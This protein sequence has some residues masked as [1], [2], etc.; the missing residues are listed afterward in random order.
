MYANKVKVEKTVIEASKDDSPNVDG[1]TDGNWTIKSL[2]AP[3]EIA[4]NDS[5]VVIFEDFL[6]NNFPIR[7]LESI[8]VERKK[9]R[10]FLDEKF[11][12]KQGLSFFDES[13]GEV[14]KPKILY[15]SN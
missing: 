15:K 8:E 12:S 5:E 4:H 13:T 1:K 10:D 3:T 2:N 11:N 6:E 14:L 7:E 9:I